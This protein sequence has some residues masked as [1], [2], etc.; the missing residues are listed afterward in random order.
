MKTI[1]ALAALACVMLTT[2]ANAADGKSKMTVAKLEDKAAV[3]A[4]ASK[5]ASKP[6][7]V[8]PARAKKVAASE[9]PVYDYR[10][11]IDGCCY[12]R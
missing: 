7:S 12:Q 11:E 8:S 4:I 9:S 3:S 6:A 5:T 1:I 10:L 2:S